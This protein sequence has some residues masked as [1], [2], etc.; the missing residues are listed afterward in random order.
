MQRIDFLK[1]TRFVFEKNLHTHSVVCD[2]TF[3]HNS[4]TIV[5]AV[6]ENQHFRGFLIR[7]SA[8]LIIYSNLT[9]RTHACNS[10]AG[11]PPS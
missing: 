1:T 3:A 7:G 2:A 5:L 6:I 10:N 8:R 11:L 4:S 9:T